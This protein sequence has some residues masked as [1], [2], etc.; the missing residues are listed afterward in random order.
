MSGKIR[1]R[2]QLFLRSS[3][4]SFSA[5]RE[6]IREGE[7]RGSVVV[8]ELLYL[9][10]QGEQEAV[11]LGV[12]RVVEEE[13]VVILNVNHSVVAG[14]NGSEYVVERRYGS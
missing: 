6:A 2:S 9:R 4:C 5:R 1:R 13:R 7:T 10:L 14:E 3:K 12:V 8:S 11:L